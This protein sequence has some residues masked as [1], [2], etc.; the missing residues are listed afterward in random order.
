MNIFDKFN[1]GIKRI[2]DLIKVKRK[3]VT[4]GQVIILLGQRGKG[5]SETVK[6]LCRKISGNKYVVTLDANL[7]AIPTNPDDKEDYKKLPGCTVIEKNADILWEPGLYIFEDFPILTKN[8]SNDLYN[9]IKTARHHGL[10]FLIV[11]HDYRVL[12]NTVFPHSN[13]ILL[14]QDPV[15]TPHQL[16]PKVGG[17]GFGYSISRALKDLQQYHYIFVSFDHKMWH[18]PFLDSRDVDVLTKAVR[19]NLISSELSNIYYPK[20]AKNKISKPKRD[21]KTELL[22][23]LLQ[24]GLSTDEICSALDTTPG[25]IWKEKV[26][27]K[28]RYETLYGKKNLKGYLKDNRKNT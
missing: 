10:N 17:L 2:N 7:S 21:T 1:D 15:I 14:Y 3:Q 28:K 19:G 13:A 12:R 18:N 22:D 6:S 11:A 16:A 27:I 20:K 5:K 4:H 8:A 26:I 25:F 23:P 9:K 24:I